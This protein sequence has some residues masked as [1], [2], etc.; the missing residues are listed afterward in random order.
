MQRLALVASRDD[1]DRPLSGLDGEGWNAPDTVELD[2]GHLVGD[3]S[4]GFHDQQAGEGLLPAF[5]GL[6]DATDE[7]VLSFARRWGVLH[8]CHHGLPSGHDA[9]YDALRD[10]RLDGD[11]KMFC[12]RAHGPGFSES[13][14]AWRDYA[15][16]ASGLVAL[17][18]R[19][20][21]GNA[22]AGPVGQRAYLHAVVGLGVERLRSAVKAAG[23]RAGATADWRLLDADVAQTEVSFRQSADDSSPAG[24]GG[25]VADMVGRWLELGRVGLRLQWDGQGFGVVLGGEDLPGL[26]GALAGKLF[27]AVTGRSM[28]LCYHC[29]NLFQPKRNPAVG[30]RSYCVA[31][32]EAH[33]PNRDS[34]RDSYRRKHAQA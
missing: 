18:L 32:R 6:A 11:R 14:D 22:A 3:W 29:G 28:A 27:L 26:F 25:M 10:K 34:A 9:S 16:R 4:H 23:A 7:M 30:H 15:A 17:S 24:L 13:T 21:D 5:L 19:L 1:D 20:R 8:L 2:D 31:C 12:F 33:V